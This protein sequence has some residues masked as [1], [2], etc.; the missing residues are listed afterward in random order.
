MVNTSFRIVNV[1]LS[2]PTS[3]SEILPSPIS[4]GFG[5]LMP[6]L[7]LR[8]RVSAAVNTNCCGDFCT[9]GR[10]NAHLMKV[11]IF[12]YL[13]RHPLPDCYYY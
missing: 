10:E 5:N 11:K 12:K 13:N 3:G 1:G 8:L 9:V 7:R 2:I 6:D 4:K